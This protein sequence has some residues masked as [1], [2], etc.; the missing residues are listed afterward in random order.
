MSFKL[1][2]P[3]KRCAGLI[4]FFSKQEYLDDFLSG[5]LYCNTPEFYR[6]STAT[7]VSDDFEACMAYFNRNKHITPPKI[8]IDGKPLDLS[9]VETLTIFGDADRHDS[10][11][12]CWFA[13]DQPTDFES[14]VLALRSNLDQVRLE[15]GPFSVFLPASNLDAYGRLLEDAVPD[16]YLGSHV[17][18]TD[19]YRIRGMFRKRNSYSYQREYRFAIGQVEKGHLPHRVLQMPSLDHLV[20]VCPNL[21][22]QNGDCTICILPALAA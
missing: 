5:S 17:Q 22:I 14:G 7:G 20:E 21:F 11:L 3:A 6:Q 13:V 2:A 4:K 12:Q 1:S 16:G 18:Y 15:S 19:D 10:H 9:A 8:V